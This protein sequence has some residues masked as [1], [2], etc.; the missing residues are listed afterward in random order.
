MPRIKVTE[1]EAVPDS[2]VLSAGSS[3]PRLEDASVTLRFRLISTDDRSLEAL[4]YAR[5]AMLREESTRGVD[6]DEPSLERAVFTA[7][8]VVWPVPALA[9][10]GGRAKLE[11]LVARANR[12][13]ADMSEASRSSRVVPRPRTP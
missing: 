8:E 11:E 4:R 10:E 3:A 1:I 7:F 6:E 12:A 2:T 9:R 13:L 5:R